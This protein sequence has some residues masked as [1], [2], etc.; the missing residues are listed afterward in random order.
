VAA[1]EKEIVQ[2]LLAVSK[3]HNPISET[4][5]T[6]RVHGHLRIVV[7]VL[8]EKYLYSVIEVWHCGLPK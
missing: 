8:Y 2:G 1:V 4:M 6:Q 5:V 7:A 3:T